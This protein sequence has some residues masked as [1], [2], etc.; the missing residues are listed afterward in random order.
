MATKPLKNYTISHS[1]SPHEVG[2]N[3]EVTLNIFNAKMFK[4]SLV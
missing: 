4:S 1:I 3:G 2:R